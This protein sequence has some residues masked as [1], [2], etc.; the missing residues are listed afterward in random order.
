M[1]KNPR[2]TAQE[3]EK[4]LLKAG[5]AFLRQKGSHK[6]YIRNKERIVIPHHPGKVLHPKIVAQVLAAIQDDDE[7]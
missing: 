7:Q 4:R 3:A 1:P 5:F 2:L 6:I